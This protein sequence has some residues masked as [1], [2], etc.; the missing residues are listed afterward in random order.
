MSRAAPN[1]GG[2]MGQRQAEMRS[3]TKIFSRLVGDYMRPATVVLPADRGLA[4]VLSAMVEYKASSAL[5]TGPSS[6]AREGRLV[7]I[8]TEKDVTRRIALRCDGS[9][10]ADQLMTSPVQAVAV[11]DFLY[12]A[13]ADMRRFGWRHM[14]VVD[15]LERPV[16]V[17]ALHEALS[18]A[19]EEVLR[20]IDL[21]SHE[22]SL[23]GLAAIKTAQVE[24][25]DSLLDDNVP[26]SEIQ[27]L[28]TQINND[29]HRR[30]IE[31]HLA[32]MEETGWG[33]PPVEFCLIIMGSGGRGENY[34][35]PDQDNGFIIDDYPDAE[36]ARID[37]FFIELAERLNRDLDRIG[38]PYCNGHVMARNPLW[39]KTRSQWRAQIGMWGRKRSTLAVQL[40][41]I[42]F[43]FRGAYGVIEWARDLRRDVTAMTKASP[44]FL[45]ELHGEVSRNQVAL[46][47]FGR[48]IT[49]K[50]NPE[51]KG[52]L[53]LKHSGTLPL[54]S[55]LRLLAL[56]HGVEAT[57]TKAR[58]DALHEMGV[59]NRDEWDY[60]QGAFDHITGLLLRQQLKDFQDP[61]RRVGNF[62]HPEEISERE[63]D[64]LVDSFKAIGNLAE[65]VTHEFT[66]DIF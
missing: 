45:R 38:F 46:G 60:L 25:A 2:A 43:D 29:I 3:Q 35:Y 56:T 34:L 50:D 14:P 24:L 15:A 6:G 61:G 63:R 65:R 57:G 58:I 49:E 26:A 28:I 11:D 19:G 48:L 66:G 4:E 13:I 41:D 10:A 52:A 17:I 32:A 22:G 5:I 64:M 51:H 55:N 9:E 37:G 23:E 27:Q 1:S 54:V 42:F 36:H 62:V 12:K 47:W 40:S 18:V 53:N 8:I 7:G 59:L 31:A 39:R 20:R 16:G 21:L 44:A 30:V 33:A